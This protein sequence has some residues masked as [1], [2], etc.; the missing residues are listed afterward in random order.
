MSLADH[1]RT[2]AAPP[3]PPEWRPRHDV[4]TDGGYV[5][6]KPTDKPQLNTAEQATEIRSRGLD[7]A[8]WVVTG[9]RH[10]S[11][12][13]YD[14]RTLHAH[15]LS[16]APARGP[17]APLDV[18]DLMR[19]AAKTKPVAKRATGNAAYVWAV[20]DQQAGKSDGDGTAGMVARFHAH[21]ERVRDDYR[22]TA[23]RD[24]L[25]HL[26]LAL[27]GDHV[28]GFVSQDGRNAWTTELTITEQVRLYRRLILHA[29]KRLAPLA[30]TMTVAGVGG[31][32]GEAMR[33]PV[34]TR[35]D[36]NWDVEALIAVADVI[37]ELPAFEHVKC[38]VPERDTGHLVLNVAGTT[39]GH[40]HGHLMPRA[41]H[42]KWWQGHAF[43]GDPLA[44][45]QLLLAGH[46][47]S[48]RVEQDGQRS[49]IQA[50][51]LES[52]STWYKNATGTVGNPGTV[53]FV[54]QD[55]DWANLNV[56]R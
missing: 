1:L 46:F 15:R 12:D 17:G 24:G 3:A 43:N 38:H 23:K 21:V 44:D 56:V 25:G 22:A 39:I 33:R 30:E 32:H 5:V 34:S 29:I 7:P 47:H 55:G 50:P 14:G 40:T 11:W 52:Q 41:Q 31:N 48:L 8:Q 37:A 6:T 42:W 28:E 13:A 53:T 9:V 18:D 19:V 4:G 54:T 20:A 26:H 27:L 2:P 51:S 45:A 35:V 49:F 36:D 16:L 10:S